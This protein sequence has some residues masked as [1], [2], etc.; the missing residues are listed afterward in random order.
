M[1]DLSECEIGII[2]YITRIPLRK[3]LLQIGKINDRSE[4]AIGDWI[5]DGPENVEIV[6]YHGEQEMF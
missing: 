4:R 2:F 5:D 3:E 6:D 1:A